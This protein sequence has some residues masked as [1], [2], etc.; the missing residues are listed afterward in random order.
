MSAASAEESPVRLCTAKHAPPSTRKKRS[1]F[2]LSLASGHALTYFVRAQ[3]IRLLVATAVR[4]LPP[5]AQAR[6]RRV[7][8]LS[9]HVADVDAAVRFYQEALGFRATTAP[10]PAAAHAPLQRALLGS[11]GCQLEFFRTGADEEAPRAALSPMLGI[12]ASNLPG[13]LVKVRRKGGS[14]GESTNRA[15][16][17]GAEEVLEAR[18]HAACLSRLPLLNLSLPTPRARSLGGRARRRRRDRALAC[19]PRAAPAA[20][21]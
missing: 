12:A 7:S 20:R 11:D 6:A 1:P 16:W 21:L 14:V 9:L 10:A 15:A 8:R 18:I 2:F 4:R 19:G 17:L 3:M 13:T 5:H